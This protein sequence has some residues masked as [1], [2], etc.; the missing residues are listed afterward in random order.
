MDEKVFAWPNGLPENAETAVSC[1]E[2]GPARNKRSTS[3]REEE[4]D[5]QMCPCGRAKESRTHVIWKCEMYNEERNVLEEM[6]KID[7]CDMENF[8]T[9]PVD[10]SEK[11]MAILEKTDGG[12]KRRN[13]K[14]IR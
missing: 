9:L 5:A 13:R 14:G 12:H 7:E 4:E 11:T 6:E 1:M 8:G 3:S 10:N 2:P